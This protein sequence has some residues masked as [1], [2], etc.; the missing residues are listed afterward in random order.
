MGKRDLAVST[1]RKAVEREPDSALASVSLANV[2]VDA[3][4]LDEA[5]AA[6]EKVLSI[7]PTLTLTRIAPGICF[8]KDPKLNEKKLEN[9]R[10]AGIPE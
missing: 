3:D 10:K 7:D 8:Y 2:L 4:R 9:L 5:T 6:A 1:L